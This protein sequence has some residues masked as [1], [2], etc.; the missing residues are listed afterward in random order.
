MKKVGI[1]GGTFNPI[2]NGHLF[3]AEY[4]YEQIGLDRVLFMPSKNPPHK[5]EMDIISSEHRLNMV[6]LA[7]RD[8][9]HFEVSTFEMDREGITYT[10][11]TLSLLTK[12][13]PDTEYYFIV[14]A[15]SLLMMTK[16]MNPQ[17]VFK[18]C[19]IVAASRNHLP[20]RQLN[21]QAKLLRESYGASI[22]MLDMPTLEIS[23]ASIRERNA[24][25]KSIMYYLPKSV[26]DY[27]KVHGLYHQ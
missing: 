4:A 23:S 27:I 1:M 3:L 17:I 24:T 14:G 22:I 25:D 10:A 21:I 6:M 8:N 2:H 13:N 15:D 5:E 26:N 11:D 9:P 7:T 19:T 16:W 18:L 12:E 20:Q